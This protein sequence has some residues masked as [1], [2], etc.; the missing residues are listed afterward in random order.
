MRDLVGRYVALQA[1]G[2]AQHVGTALAPEA[3]QAARTIF[4]AVTAVRRESM[5]ISAVAARPAARSRRPPWALRAGVRDGRTKGLHL[6]LG[7]PAWRVRAM[8]S[9]SR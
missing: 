8:C 1:A 6:S 2:V 3:S 9:I 5:R 4:T 7:C